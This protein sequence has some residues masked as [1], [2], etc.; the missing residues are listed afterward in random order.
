MDLWAMRVNRK[1]KR[2]D[3]RENYCKTMNV[4][5]AEYV[6]SKCRGGMKEK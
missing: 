2:E 6:E 4:E 5:C 1:N 3:W